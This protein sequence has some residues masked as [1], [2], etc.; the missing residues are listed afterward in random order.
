MKTT[1]TE[2]IYTQTRRQRPISTSKGRVVTS[3]IFTEGEGQTE[4]TKDGYNVNVTKLDER[5]WAT[6]TLKSEPIENFDVR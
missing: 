1:T 2:Y 4:P 5:G 6:L 3:L